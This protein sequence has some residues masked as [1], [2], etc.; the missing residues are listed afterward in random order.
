MFSMPSLLGGNSQTCC[1]GNCCASLLSVS[2]GVFPVIMLSRPGSR[3]GPG[4]MGL[5]ALLGVGIGGI[6]GAIVQTFVP[7]YEITELREAL[8]QAFDQARERGQ[9]FDMDRD[10]F[11]RTVVAIA[12]YVVVLC[13]GASSLLA[14]LF[15]MFAGALAK[16]EP[17]LRR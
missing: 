6:C 5:A 16:H 14:G 11:V 4:T 15:G 1:A 12:P 17:P 2:F 8:G 7:G 10:E 13:A 9:S 3:Y